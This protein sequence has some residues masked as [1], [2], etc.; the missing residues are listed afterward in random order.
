[1]KIK[2]NSND[3]FRY[4]VGNTL[5]DPV[6]SCI[7]SEN[8]YEVF[9]NGIFDHTTKQILVQNSSFVDFCEAVS[10]LKSKA[11]QLPTEE[12][13]FHCKSLSSVPIEI[14]LG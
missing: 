9:D 5:R 8:R 14:N 13:F 7:D 3:V 12:I 6:E 11:S 4:V 1:M 2:T 10:N